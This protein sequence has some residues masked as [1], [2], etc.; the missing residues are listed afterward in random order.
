M[1]TLYSP[2][3]LYPKAMGDMKRVI[4]NTALHATPHNIISVTPEVTVH[5]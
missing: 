2:F 3:I 5:D 4:N 1:A